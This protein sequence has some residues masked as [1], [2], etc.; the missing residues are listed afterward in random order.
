MTHAHSAESQSSQKLFQIHTVSFPWGETACA[1]T[2]TRKGEKSFPHSWTP[3]SRH[4][5]QRGLSLF[6]AL[7]H[8]FLPCP[9]LKRIS[10]IYSQLGIN[11]HVHCASTGCRKARRRNTHNPLKLHTYS[12]E[13]P[14]MGT[15]GINTSP[16]KLLFPKGARSGAC[17][18]VICPMQMQ[19]LLV[20]GI[21]FD[22]FCQLKNLSLVRKNK[23]KETK[24]TM[25]IETPED[26]NDYNKR[27]WQ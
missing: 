25:A 8:C 6:L 26:C 4:L 21:E 16:R 14:G 18:A 22:T 3:H 10:K 23:N 27:Q 24:Q 20:A 9:R 5:V 7:W 19:S 12:S 15:H 2:R 11:V 1:S 17:T 13:A